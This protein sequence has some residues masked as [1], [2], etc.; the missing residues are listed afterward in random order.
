MER[1]QE[2]KHSARQ[3]TILLKSYITGVVA[4]NIAFVPIYGWYIVF[5]ILGSFF[6]SAPAF[7]VLLILYVLNI[8]LV[9]S[10]P[11]VF[12]IIASIM[13]LTFHF[14]AFMGVEGMRGVLR[15][16][17]P[18]IYHFGLPFLIVLFSSCAFI[19]LIRLA[20]IKGNMGVRP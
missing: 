8:E 20:Q 15:L 5:T 16:E 1:T 9:N 2:P 3:V 19:T 18:H 14:F 17:E 6:F 7:A 4:A 13:A 10:R 12:S 11:I